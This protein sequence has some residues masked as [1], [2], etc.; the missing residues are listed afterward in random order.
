M[1]GHKETLAYEPWPSHDPAIL[2]EKEEEIVLQVMGKV[3]S[4]ISVPVD[5]GQD[6][7]KELALQDGKVRQWTEGKKIQKIIVVPHKLVNFV[8]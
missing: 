8:V 3:R 1:L 4:R 6:A 5:I 7:L 2:A